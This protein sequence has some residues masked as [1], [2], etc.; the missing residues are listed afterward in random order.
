MILSD[1]TEITSEIIWKMSLEIEWTTCYF[2]KNDTSFLLKQAVGL[3]KQAQITRKR[4]KYLKSALKISIFKPSENRIIPSNIF[5]VRIL[6]LNGGVT[7]VK[8][9]LIWLFIPSSPKAFEP[10]HIWGIIV[11]IVVLSVFLFLEGV[12]FYIVKE[13]KEVANNNQLV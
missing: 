8:I 1:E 7:I 10:E 2:I 6:A 3:Y 9:T 13:E 4:A 5:W 12:S 11:Q